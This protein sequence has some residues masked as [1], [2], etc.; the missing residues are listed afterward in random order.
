MLGWPADSE[1]MGWVGLS[2]CLLGIKTDALLLFSTLSCR[3]CR[4]PVPTVPEAHQTDQTRP[5]K[6]REAERGMVRGMNP[7]TAGWCW[8]TA[9][10]TSDCSGGLG[11]VSRTISSP[12]QMLF[13]TIHLFT[14]SLVNWGGGFSIPSRDEAIMTD[15]EQ[16]SAWIV[17]SNLLIK[18]CE[19]RLRYWDCNCKISH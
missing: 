1:Q 12:V 17:C 2:W 4:G 10:S 14:L 13:V 6:L 16:I 5:G 3:L 11:L 7:T 9:P 15:V 19:G 8:R 18:G